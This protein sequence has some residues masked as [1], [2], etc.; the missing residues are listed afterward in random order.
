MLQSLYNLHLVQVDSVADV[1]IAVIASC[2]DE[3]AVRTVAHASYLLGVYL[4]LGKALSHVEIPNAHG[5]IQMANSCEAIHAHLWRLPLVGNPAYARQI[6]YLASSFEI[7]LIRKCNFV[8]LWHVSGVHACH[9]LLSS[10]IKN[11]NLLVCPNT[12]G[13]AAI[14]S[15]LDTVNIA[16]V[17]LQAGKLLSVFWIPNFHVTVTLASW[18][19]DKIIRWV[20]AHRANDS[21][22]ALKGHFKYLVRA[23]VKIWDHEQFNLAVVAATSN[24]TFCAWPVNAVDRAYMMVLLLEH[25]FNLIVDLVLVF[26]VEVWELADF[27]SLAIG[28]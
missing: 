20:K 10:Y 8:H 12:Y 26:N 11:Q 1:D 21:L 18:K 25:N 9:C 14:L 24:Q 6:L 5:A 3:A 27:Q 2:C 16:L 4:L 19:Q 13:K 7:I 17:S 23:F 22:M 28:T 15:H